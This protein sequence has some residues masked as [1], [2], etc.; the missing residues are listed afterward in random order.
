MQCALLLHKICTCIHLIQLDSDLVIMVYMHLCTQFLLLKILRHWTAS[1]ISRELYLGRIS[2]SMVT[3]RK[4][5]LS[6][7]WVDKKPE[8]SRG[9]IMKAR[10]HSFFHTKSGDSTNEMPQRAGTIMLAVV[11]MTATKTMFTEQSPQ[12][13]TGGS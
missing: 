2:A 9:V 7:G 5:Q 13:N 11:M 8:K 6:S 10:F 3:Y 4:L 1:V 12:E